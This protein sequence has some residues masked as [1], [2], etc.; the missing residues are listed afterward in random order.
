MTSRSSR[1]STHDSPLEVD[2]TDA[3]VDEPCLITDTTEHMK[4]YFFM[5]RNMDHYTL[6]RLEHGVG[7]PWGSVNVN[8]HLNSVCLSRGIC[9]AF[10]KGF[11]MLLPESRIMELIAANPRTPIV[12][13]LKER[14]YNYHLMSTG[15]ICVIRRR[16]VVEGSTV[17]RKYQHPFTKYPPITC[18]VHPFFVIWSAMA[19]LN[20]DLLGRYFGSYPLKLC[21]SYRE[22]LARVLE[23]G[24]LW[25][26]VIPPSSC[27]YTA[28]RASPS[29]RDDLNNL[30]SYRADSRSFEHALAHVS[31]GDHCLDGETMQK[32]LA[33]EHRRRSRKRRE[34]FIKEWVYRFSRTQFD[35]MPEDVVDEEDDEPPRRRSKQAKPSSA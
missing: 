28:L 22:T 1:T 18:T 30:K 19:R 4:R 10:E 15:N 11:L 24:Y 12:D 21:A 25:K 6:S 7:L 5:P 34:R 13:L 20:W 27:F 16:V 17:S 35:P 23:C 9:D 32:F 26:R 8:S 14:T 3:T 31:K 2:H 33:E 29:Q